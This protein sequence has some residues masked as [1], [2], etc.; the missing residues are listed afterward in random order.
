MEVVQLIE[1]VVA[2]VVAVVVEAHPTHI[3]QNAT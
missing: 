3:Q 1:N 2:V